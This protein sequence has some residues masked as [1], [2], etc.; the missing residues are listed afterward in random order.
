MAGKVSQTAPRPLFVFLPHTLRI[1][2][3]KGLYSGPGKS[4]LSDNVM[5]S[6]ASAPQL[7]HFLSAAVAAT[8]HYIV[9]QESLEDVLLFAQF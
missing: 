9:A 2:G 1:N 4:T 5:G 6:L 8:T 3:T 7:C